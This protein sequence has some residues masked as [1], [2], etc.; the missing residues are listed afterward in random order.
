MRL[1]KKTRRSAKIIATGSVH[2]DRFLVFAS[3]GNF[4]I[5]LN[6]SGIAY[7]LEMSVEEA[8]EVGKRLL[9]LNADPDGSY[10]EA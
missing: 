1:I 4:I 3:C 10:R 2:N 7:R 5:R 6:D 8:R 9:E